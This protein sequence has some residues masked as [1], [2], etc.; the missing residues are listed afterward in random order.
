VE[1][2]LERMDRL[3]MRNGVPSDPW[4]IAQAVDLVVLVRGDPETGRRVR[5]LAFVERRLD[6]RGRFVVRRF[7]EAGELL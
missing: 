1:G 6:D 4:L 2:C 3:C 7:D 5:D